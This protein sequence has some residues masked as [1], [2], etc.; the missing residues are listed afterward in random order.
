M[1]QPI[2]FVPWIE[3]HTCQS[4]MLYPL[5]NPSCP[6]SQILLDLTG[7]PVSQGMSV[8]LVFVD[9]FFKAC[10]FV[11]PPKL[12]LGNL[13]L[14]HVVQAHGFLKDVVSDLGPAVHELI[15][16]SIWPP[17][18]S[19]NQPLLR[20]PLQFQWSD[21]E[22]G[23]LSQVFGISQIIILGVTFDLGGICP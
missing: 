19:Y 9:Q 18:G 21:W 6:W 22:S 14:Q 10:K 13:L 11:P 2:R 16:E 17:P 5:P 12:L 20:I 4:C 3:S 8:I 23:V 1:W 15:L 7:L